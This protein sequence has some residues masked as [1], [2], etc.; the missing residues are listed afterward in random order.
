MT[1][2]DSGAALSGELLDRSFLVRLEPEKADSAWP[3]KN[4]RLPRPEKAVSLATLEKVFAPGAELPGEMIE[5]VRL[6][7]EKLAAKGLYLSRRALTDLYNYCSAVLPY[8]TCSFMET[9]DY[10]LSARV[11]PTLLA[12]ANLDALHELSRMLPDMPR[13]L[14]LLTS[15]LPMPEI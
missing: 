12:T 9:L 7:R 13:C 4:G 2:Q 5:R 8:M 11:M 1:V 3:P 15:A 10:A 6:L 14:K